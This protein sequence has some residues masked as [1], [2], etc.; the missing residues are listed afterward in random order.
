VVREAVV[1]QPDP[2]APLG[3]TVVEEFF[4]GPT[5]EQFDFTSPCQEI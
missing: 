4:V 5:A 1:S 2:D 3:L